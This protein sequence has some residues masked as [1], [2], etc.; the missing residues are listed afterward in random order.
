MTSRAGTDVEGTDGYL[1]E[2]SGWDAFQNFFVE[3]T[4]FHWCPDEK[5]Q[6]RL[7]CTVRE[8]S[9]VF[10]RLLQPL[11]NSSSFPIAFQATKVLERDAAGLA[12]VQ[13]TKLLPRAQERRM[14]PAVENPVTTVA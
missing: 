11:A 13:L 8:G 3:M 9:S 2:V 6:I 1:V 5:K 12:L 4:A 10:V 7:R 14:E